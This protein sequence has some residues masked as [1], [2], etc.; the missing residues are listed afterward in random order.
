MGVPSE[1]DV[2]GYP[3]CEDAVGGEEVRTVPYKDLLEVYGR[4]SLG[5]LS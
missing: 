3:A 1:I 5:C 4:V 2:F